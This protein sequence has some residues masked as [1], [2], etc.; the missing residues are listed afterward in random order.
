M[1]RYIAQMTFDNNINPKLVIYTFYDEVPRSF[2]FDLKQR[3]IKFITVKGIPKVWINIYDYIA[4]II[5]T[6][7]NN[8]I[9]NL[10]NEDVKESMSWI[11]LTIISNNT[12]IFNH[13]M[14]NTITEGVNQGILI[15]DIRLNVQYD[16]II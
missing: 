2:L 6:A 12:S 8:V 4:T 15:N 13:I 5:V 1:Y 16:I 7:N 11:P 10:C 3:N 9:N 14:I